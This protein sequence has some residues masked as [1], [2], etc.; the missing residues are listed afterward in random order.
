MD[1]LPPRPLS[2]YPGGP[3]ASARDLGTLIARLQAVPPFPPLADYLAMVER[4]LGAVRRSNT[5]ATGLLD[6]HQGAFERIR[7]AYPWDASTHVSAHNDPNPRNIIF[8]GTRL[9]LIDWETSYRNDPLT[10]VAILVDNVAPSSEIEDALLGA[11]LG[12]APDRP[13]RARLLLMRPL[14]RLYYA[15][16]LL[17]ISTSRQ[18]RTTPDSDLAALTP[19][20]FGA[21]ATSGALRGADML[22]ALGKMHLAAFL[23]GVSVPGFDEALV[24]CAAQ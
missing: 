6:P 15:G 11:W 24:L 1:F 13:T 7:E 16:L 5:F 3:M 20:E 10:D 22:Y 9:W 21:A 19:A 4:M 17:S 18:P 8:D 14:T 12:R 23:A 2:D